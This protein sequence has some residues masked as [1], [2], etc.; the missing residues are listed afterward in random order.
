[1]HL[2]PFHEPS[3]PR[4]TTTRGSRMKACSSK[5]RIRGSPSFDSGVGNPPSFPTSVD[6]VLSRLASERARVSLESAPPLR[7]SPPYILNPGLESGRHG[8]PT[9]EGDI[10]RPPFSQSTSPE[11]APILCI[12]GDLASGAFAARTFQQEGDLGVTRSLFPLTVAPLQLSARMPPPGTPG[13]HSRW[14]LPPF[15]FVY[16]QCLRRWRRQVS[17]ASPLSCLW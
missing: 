17:R 4:D 12:F 2:R 11:P 15:D 13:R 16:H 7:L 1:L 6:S 8:F 5:K 3:F 9:F 14:H 10:S